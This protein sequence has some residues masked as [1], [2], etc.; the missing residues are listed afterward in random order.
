MPLLSLS[1]PYNHCDVQKD[2]NLST[3]VLPTSHRQ[4]QNHHHRRLRFGLR[5]P[6]CA[7]NKN[8]RIAIIVVVFVI[9]LVIRHSGRRT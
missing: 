4:P 1:D 9:N 6:T 5:D 2:S 7:Q 3:L 8:S